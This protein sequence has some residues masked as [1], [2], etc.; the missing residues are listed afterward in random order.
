MAQRTETAFGTAR[1]LGFVLNAVKEAPGKKSYNY[2]Y[3]YYYHADPE[4]SVRKVPKRVS[5]R[6]G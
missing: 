2:N 3:N 4:A 1:I 5:E 6:L